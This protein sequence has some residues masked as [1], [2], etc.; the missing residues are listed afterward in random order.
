MAK[1]QKIPEFIEAFQMTE[2]TQTN[3]KSWPEWAIAARSKDMRQIGSIFLTNPENPEGSFS[4][5][6]EYDAFEIPKDFWLIQLSGGNFMLMQDD[7]FQ[8]G[9]IPTEEEVKSNSKSKA[10][11]S[12]KKTEEAVTN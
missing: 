2:E 4:I 7:L 9:F 3:I 11:A 12:E 8:A 6:T 5:R 10:A 1:Y